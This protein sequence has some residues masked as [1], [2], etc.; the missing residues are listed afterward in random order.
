MSKKMNNSI[1][2]TSVLILMALSSPPAA[3]ASVSPMVDMLCNS[4][5]G[6]KIAFAYDRSTGD[7]HGYEEIDDQTAETK[8]YSQADGKLNLIISAEKQFYETGY[9]LDATHSARTDSLQAFQGTVRSYSVNTSGARE[10]SK[11]AYSVSC[12]EQI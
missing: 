5:A 1:G 9:I 7:L 3:K 2:L 6:T 10:I 11:A 8:Q 12:V 4:Q